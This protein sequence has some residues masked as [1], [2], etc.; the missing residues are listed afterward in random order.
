MVKSLFCRDVS[1]EY[2]FK[3]RLSDVLQNISG[4]TKE[5]LSIV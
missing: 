2:A 4:N 3:R 5:T 1:A